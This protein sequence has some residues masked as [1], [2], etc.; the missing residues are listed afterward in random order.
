MDGTKNWEKVETSPTWDFK[1]EKELVGVYMGVETDVGPNESNLY[2]FKKKGGKVIA[3]WGNT[4][5][6]N[7]FKNLVKGEEVKIIYNGLVKSE[8]TGREYHSFDVYHRE[9]EFE[10][11]DDEPIPVEDD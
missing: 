1:E 9:A 5:L 6:D 2:S 4:L 11:V 7:R 8:K 3:V 10:Q